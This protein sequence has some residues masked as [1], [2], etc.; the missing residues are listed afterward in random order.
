[1]RTTLGEDA[2][3]LTRPPLGLVILPPRLGLEVREVM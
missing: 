2:V 1:M 3:G